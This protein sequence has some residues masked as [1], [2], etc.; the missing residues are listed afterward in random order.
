MRTVIC[1]VLVVVCILALAGVL[2]PK[3]GHGEA[4]ITAAQTQLGDFGKALDMF[5]EDSGHYPSDANGLL[6]LS[7]RPR[8]AQNWHG[9]Y[10]KNELGIPLDP[11]GQ[12]YVYRCP[13]KH[14]RSF[15]DLMSLGP[16]GR[17][18]TDDDI[19]NWQKKE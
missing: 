1:I 15:Y 4:R 9:P 8:D 5:R 7:Q 12:R 2:L 6:G 14:N 3:F 16:D 10:L 19:T 18:G 11:W 13:G 17:E